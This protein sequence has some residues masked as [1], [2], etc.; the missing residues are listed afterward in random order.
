M[1]LRSLAVAFR[2]IILGYLMGP[3]FLGILCNL[4]M[5]MLDLNESRALDVLRGCIVP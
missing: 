1:A 5:G 3:G 2:T 4:G